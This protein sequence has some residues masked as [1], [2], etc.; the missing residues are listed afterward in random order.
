M[1][2]FFVVK[3]SSQKIR[4]FVVPWNDYFHW[5]K[6]QHSNKQPRDMERT[7]GREPPIEESSIDLP[8]S[9]TKRISGPLE[10]VAHNEETRERK[11]N[12]SDL[13]EQTWFLKEKNHSTYLPP[14]K[15]RFLKPPYPRVLDTRIPILAHHPTTH[16]NIRRPITNHSDKPSTICAWLWMLYS[17]VVQIHPFWW[18][19]FHWYGGH[20]CP[21]PSNE[22]KTFKDAPPTSSTAWPATS[23]KELRFWKLLATSTL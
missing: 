20:P 3:I 8:Q 10:K 5:S 6:D 17:V 15:Q 11:H 21:H 13:W 19:T 7:H 2:K 9:G 23:L 22:E 4:F 18:T 14:Y 1:K 12:K 16:G